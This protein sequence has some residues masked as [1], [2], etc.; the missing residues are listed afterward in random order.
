MKMGRT[1]VVI[2]KRW[3]M[4]ALVF[5]LAL[6]LTSCS[7]G[8]NNLYGGSAAYDCRG[9]KDSFL[10]ELYP[11]TGN[12]YTLSLTPTGLSTEGVIA[13][14]ALIGDTINQLKTV[15]TTVTLHSGMPVEINVTLDDLLNYSNVGVAHYNQNNPTALFPQ[16]TAGAICQLPLPGDGNNSSYN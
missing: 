4:V 11:Q 9:P 13:Q 14:I 5:T 15:Y 1:V 3:W 6:S 16:M 2:L 10:V 7:S 12:T 8:Q